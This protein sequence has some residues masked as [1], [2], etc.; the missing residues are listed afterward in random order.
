MGA[1]GQRVQ[2]RSAKRCRAKWS[3]S[4]G[5]CDVKTR[6]AGSTPR[7][8]PPGE[9]VGRLI[10]LCISHSTAPSMRLRIR[11]Q[12]IK[13]VALVKTTEN[14]PLLPQTHVPPARRIGRNLRHCIVWEGIRKMNDAFREIRL[15]V[16]WQRARIGQHVVKKI[17]AARP[18]GQAT[19]LNRRGT[20]RKDSES[21]P[22]AG[23]A[24]VTAIS[25]PSSRTSAAM[26]ASL[27][28]L[29]SWN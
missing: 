12:T 13:L 17:C 2:D 10:V 15:L 4:N 27:F 6:R 29:T 19:H 21:I 7:P 14:D 23:G 18:G 11:I 22:S 25:T 5:T 26:S 20:K 24:S 9:V 16:K 3:R 8:Q 28:V 1:I